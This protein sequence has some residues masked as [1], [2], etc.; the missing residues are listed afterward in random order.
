MAILIGMDEAGYGPNLGPLVVSA[1][2]WKIPGK[3]EDFDFWS[4]M[5]PVI[6]RDT[7]RGDSV[8]RIAD[9][10]EVYSPNRGF[11][12]LEASVLCGTALDGAAI[13]SLRELAWHVA[14]W[15][16][17][18]F[19]T[20][21]W[22]AGQDLDLPRSVSRDNITEWT[23]LWRRQC[24]RHAVELLAMRSDVVLTERF[25]REVANVG[26]KGQVLTRVTLQ[27]LK[28]VWD[29]ESDEPTLVICDKHGGRNRYDEFIAEIVEDRM[30]SRHDESRNLSRYRVG[31]TEFRFQ[32]RAE[33]HLPVALASMLCK[34]TREAAME[35]FNT[36]WTR[37]IDGLKPTK[38]YP[39][40]AKRF[41][42]D[43]ADKQS[44]LGIKDATL[45]REK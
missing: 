5:Q 7:P 25:N 12:Y 38:G 22:F 31:N 43:I 26:S 23:A 33:E 9:S 13:T 2:A 24:E 11:E 39:L 29:L 8:L 19:E 21:P 44:Q 1:T 45:W 18:D 16:V 4:A 17:P 20:E 37:H 14:P 41:K 36:Y 34:Y 30:I 15:S 27:L 42:R 28:H 32:T 6:S 10:K 3:I 40:D 35:L